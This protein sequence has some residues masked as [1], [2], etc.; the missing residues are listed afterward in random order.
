MN[1]GKT[2]VSV[3]T[4]IPGFRKT[5]HTS[6]RVTTSVG[7]PGTGISYVDTKKLDGFG[8]NAG[9]QNQRNNPATPPT[10]S[11]PNP[12]PTP[13]YSEG[14]MERPATPP[15]VTQFQTDTLKS[16]HKTCDDPID[17]TEVLVSPEPPDPSFPSELWSFY[18][19]VSNN[20]L[21]GDIDTY[22]QLIYEV[23]PLDDLL[24][25]GG[26]FQFG[27]DDARKIEVEFVVNEQAINQA[28]SNLSNKDFYDLIQDFVCST[29]IRIARDMFA[30]LPIENTVVHGV[31]KG[32]TV[33]S[34]NFDRSGLSKIK[35]NFA[36]PSDVTERFPHEMDFD[37]TRGFRGVKRL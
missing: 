21:N 19:S 22:L 29:A 26:E 30:L 11:A 18:H 1:L 28:K 31:L 17:W 35:L 36:D 12:M 14:V 4:G 23:N 6:G 7:I 24:A 3:S 8:S 5:F 20:V 25:F 37:V 10:A 27:T 2:G 15:P 16:I 9:G 34:V 33:L 32:N 13:N